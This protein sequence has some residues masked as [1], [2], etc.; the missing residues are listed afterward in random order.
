MLWDTVTPD[1]PLYLWITDAELR[2]ILQRNGHPGLSEFP[3]Q[4]WITTGELTE[5]MTRNL[6]KLEASRKPSSQQKEYMEDEM[7]ISR[8]RGALARLQE[9][10]DPQHLML[11]GAA[12]IPG[13]HMGGQ[14]YVTLAPVP[15]NAVTTH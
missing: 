2:T 15:T 4:T 13:A 10:T 1:E 7:W 12:R 3:V 8:R 6:S 9:S 11:L 5:I 14:R